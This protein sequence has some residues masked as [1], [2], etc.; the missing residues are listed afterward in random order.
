M[1]AIA[2]VTAR[3]LLSA[4]LVGTIV[5]CSGATAPVLRAQPAVPDFSSGQKTW[6]LMNGT[7]FF[8]VPGDSGPGPIVDMPGH[9]YVADYNTR[10]ADTTNP[11]LKPWAKK[12]M[13]IANQRVLAGG[14]PFYPTSR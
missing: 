12:L 4:V 3:H 2:R 14:I 5:L 7:A 8:K 10:V 1:A 6:V 11:I 9:E 13:D